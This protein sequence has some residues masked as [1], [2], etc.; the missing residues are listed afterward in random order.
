[1]PFVALLFGALFAAAF[2]FGLREAARV[3]HHD[4]AI[5]PAR[6]F[7]RG[8]AERARARI[9][10]LGDLVHAGFVALGIVSLV[11]TLA[12]ALLVF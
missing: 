6:A 1:M 2:R 12:A 10:A 11:G 5:P 3:A 8:G 4:G 9:A 7:P